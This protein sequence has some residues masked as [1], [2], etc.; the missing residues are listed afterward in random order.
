VARYRWFLFPLLLCPLALLVRGDSGDRYGIGQTVP[1]SGKLL[2][3]GKPLQ[4]KPNAFARVWFHPD[5]AKGNKCPQVASGDVDSVGNYT[6]S[7]RG[8]HG[9]PPG[10]YK[11][12]V[13]ATEHVDPRQPKKKRPSFIQR[14]YGNV[15]TSGLRIEVVEAAG[16][17]RYDLKL[18]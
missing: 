13:I 5:A 9:V 10:W 17:G 3:N 12:M 7:M 15:G 18:R 4:L 14:K 8:Q 6:L 2:V 11:V 1:V 16:A